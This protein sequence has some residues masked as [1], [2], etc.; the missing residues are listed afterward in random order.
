MRGQGDERESDREA[1]ARE[2]VERHDRGG[3]RDHE[4][5]EEDLGGRAGAA[6]DGHEAEYRKG[7]HDPVGKQWEAE[8]R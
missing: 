3:V 6:E 5:G 7:D 1:I 2:D 4:E 8:D